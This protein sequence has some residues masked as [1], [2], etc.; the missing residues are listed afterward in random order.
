VNALQARQA[1]LQLLEKQ[2]QL[3]AIRTKIAKLE[4]Q[5]SHIGS[6]LT[7]CDSIEKLLKRERQSAIERHIA[8][9]GPMI[10]LI[11]QRLRSVYGFGGIH[12]EAHGGEAT[13]QVDGG[14]KAF[15]FRRRI[16]LVTLKDRF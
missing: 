16:F 8:A 7:V 14:I 2:A 4:G 1:R 10:T 12:L 6:V 3:D 11:Q 13:V 5:F 9:Y 15:K